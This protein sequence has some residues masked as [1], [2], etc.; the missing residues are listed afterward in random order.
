MSHITQG[1]AYS[2]KYFGAYVD[3]VSNRGINDMLALSEHQQQLG[4]G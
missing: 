3:R 4:L 1:F 2:A